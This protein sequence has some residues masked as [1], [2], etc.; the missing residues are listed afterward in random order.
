M[1]KTGLKQEVCATLKTYSRAWM[2]AD[3]WKFFTAR[4]IIPFSIGWTTLSRFD[5][6]MKNSGVH[7]RDSVLK[8]LLDLGLYVLYTLYLCGLDS[9]NVKTFRLDIE[10]TY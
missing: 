5:E 1:L 10:T 8:Y 2:T 6:S 9:R 7:Y 4:I 3:E